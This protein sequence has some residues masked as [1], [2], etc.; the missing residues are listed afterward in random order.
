MFPFMS[1]CTTL[2]AVEPSRSKRPTTASVAWM[3][4]D[5]STPDDVIG[6]ST[7]DCSQHACLMLPTVRIVSKYMLVIL[8]RTQHRRASPQAG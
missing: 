2:K 6:T 3:N 8:L 5:V 1:A 7:Y 4:C